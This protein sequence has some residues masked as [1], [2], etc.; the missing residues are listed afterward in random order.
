MLVAMF[1]LVLGVLLREKDLMTVSLALE[2]D[3][4]QSH[5]RSLMAALEAVSRIYIRIAYLWKNQQL[6][7]MG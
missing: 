4:L 2:S 7:L 6:N 5:R 3:E 1:Q